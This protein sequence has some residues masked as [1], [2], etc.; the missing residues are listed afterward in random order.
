MRDVRDCQACHVDLV[1][2][3]SPPATHMIHDDDYVRRHG[4]QAAAAADLCATCHKQDFCSECHGVTAP[5][6][7]ARLATAGALRPQHLDGVAARARLP[8]RFEVAAFGGVPVVPRL[9]A[10]A[11][12]WLVGGRVGRQLGDW[13]GAGVALLERREQGRLAARE[14]GLDGSIARGRADVAARV[15][16]DLVDPTVADVDLVAT[17]RWRTVRAELSGQHRVASHLL[18]ATSLFSVLGDVASDRVGGALRWRAAPR[19]DLLADLGGRA[20]DGEVAADAFARATLRLD[21]GGRGTI[22]AELR[23][24]GAVDGGWKINGFKKFAS[25]AGYCDY[26]TIVCTEVF[27]G[28]EPLH[29]DTMLF[30]VH[31]DAPDDKLKKQNPE[32]I[33]EKVVNP[34]EMEAALARLDRFNLART[35][36]FEPRR[37]PAIPSFVA[38]EGAGLLYMPVRSGPEA[39]VQAW[40]VR[41]GRGGLVGDFV[42]KTLRQWKKANP[43]HRSFTV[44]RHPLLRAHQAFLTQIVSGKLAE[45][46]ASLIRSQ[47]ADLP[48]PGQPFLDLAQHRDSLSLIHI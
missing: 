8:H 42:Q 35:P 7:G 20:V 28:I 46:R 5:T 6:L 22:T 3:G 23:R 16:V 43:G 40:M 39:H 33:G 37:P 24:T 10:N 27:E 25:L 2:E 41:L 19:L 38:V 47:K 31:K 17:R 26:Y 44:I 34:A 32:G 9:G 36:N 11:W 18:P 45:H 1:E 13:G 29:E 15:A 30:V 48:P 21:D 4:P 14:L 12:D